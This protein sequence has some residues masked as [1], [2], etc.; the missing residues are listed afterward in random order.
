[1]SGSSLGENGFQFRE[2]LCGDSI[3]DSIIS[4]DNDIRLVSFGIGYF[5]VDGDNLRDE[6]S[7]GLGGERFLVGSGGESIL[8]DSGNSKLS[9]NVLTCCGVSAQSSASVIGAGMTATHW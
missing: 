7:G 9:S 6:L 3:S 4:I 1:M 2:T 8:L 5:G